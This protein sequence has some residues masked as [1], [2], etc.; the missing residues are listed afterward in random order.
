MYK[1]MSTLESFFSLAAVHTIVSFL[2][3][4]T[5]RDF[6]SFLVLNDEG[7]GSVDDAGN[8][9][10]RDEGDAVVGLEF[11]LLHGEVGADLEVGC[12]QFSSA[13]SMWTMA[14]ME[15]GRRLKRASFVV[16]EGVEGSL[17]G[18]WTEMALRR[19]LSHCC[20]W[21]TSLTCSVWDCA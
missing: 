3:P 18:L 17:R 20:L 12:G 13:S 11:V 9:D 8:V 6:L 21:N 2:F 15:D 19:Q 7:E 1:N 5:Y 14:E 4:K 16:G 10:E